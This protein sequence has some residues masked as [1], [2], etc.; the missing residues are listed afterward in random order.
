MRDQ[1]NAFG[2]AQACFQLANHPTTGPNERAVALERGYAIARRYG[3]DVDR[4]TA[5]PCTHS[6]EP[7][8]TSDQREY[9]DAVFGQI[10]GS[11]VGCGGVSSVNALCR[12]CS[13]KA[14]NSTCLHGRHG[15]CLE[16]DP[17]EALR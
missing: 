13:L 9:V 6:C 5:C 8:L 4:L 2:K 10:F 16:C 11:C 17:T 14:A 7:K 3:F 1:H 15:C 12:A